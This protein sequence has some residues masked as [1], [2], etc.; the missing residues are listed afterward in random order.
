MT[1]E[2]VDRKAMLIDRDGREILTLNPVGTLVWESL[3]GTRTPDGIVSAVCAAFP[4]APRN[5][6]EADVHA[7]IDDLRTSGLLDEG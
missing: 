7:F 1:Y 6:V 4:D 3:D 2:V 5:T